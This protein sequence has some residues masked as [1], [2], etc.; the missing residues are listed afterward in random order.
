MAGGPRGYPA[1]PTKRDYPLP[2]ITIGTRQ[3][4]CAQ[5]WRNQLSPAVLRWTFA[6]LG[7][8][9]S[10]ALRAVSKLFER[11]HEPLDELKAKFTTHS[12]GCFAQ[13]A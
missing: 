1:C 4:G 13:C 3:D 7:G 9:N 10:R 12:H 5:S 6:T 8:S 11:A 2:G